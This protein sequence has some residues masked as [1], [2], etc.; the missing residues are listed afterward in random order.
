MTIREMLRLTSDDIRILTA[1]IHGYFSLFRMALEESGYYEDDGEKKIIIC[2]D[3]FDRGKEA[4]QLQNCLLSLM[5]NDEVILIRGNHEDLFHDLVT[6]DRGLRYG[7][8]VLNGTFQTALDLTGYDSVMAEIRHFDFAE[9]G[10][11]TPF[12][13][14]IIPSMPDYYETEHYIFVHGWIPCLPGNPPGFDPAWRNS[15][16]WKT[17]RRINGMDAADAGI[18]EAGKT[19]VCGHWHCSYG[20]SKYEGICSEFGPD[21]DFSPY[22]AHG[23]IAL[24]ACTSYSGRVNVVVLE[25]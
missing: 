22:Y 12:F 23:V 9:A 11:K 18:T 17:A 6:T 24:D 13:T 21:A 1:D 16:T 2:G 5:E 3:L 4:V 10:R 8:H 15:S 7:H 20:H 14:R 25:D 19:I